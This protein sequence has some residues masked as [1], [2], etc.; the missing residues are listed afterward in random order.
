MADPIKIRPAEGLWVV[1][2]GG[3][4]LGETEAALELIEGS[5][6]PVIYF[7]RSDIAM[8]F[9]EKSPT[10]SV[11]P[12]KGEAKYYSI[13]EQDGTIRDAVWSYEAPKAGMEAIAGYLSFYTNMVEVE[14][15]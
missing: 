10:T 9:L 5:Y 4:V 6:P 11:C 2:T 14:R 3:A 15:V 13:V 1:R 8:A 12:H 7:P